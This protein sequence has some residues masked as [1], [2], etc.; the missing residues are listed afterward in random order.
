MTKELRSTLLDLG[1]LII[2]LVVIFAVRA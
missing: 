1:A 2:T